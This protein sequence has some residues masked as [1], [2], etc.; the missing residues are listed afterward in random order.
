VFGGRPVDRVLTRDSRETPSIQL[1]DV[2]L[3]A[4]LAAWEKEVTSEAKLDLQTWIARHL[5]WPDLGGHTAERTKVQR[6][7]LL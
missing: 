3:G 7:G 1:C 6:V 2:L 5:G 4:V